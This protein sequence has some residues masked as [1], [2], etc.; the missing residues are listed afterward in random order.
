MNE[1]E[2]KQRE[3]L[4][5]LLDTPAVVQRVDVITPSRLQIAAM[6]MTAMLSNATYVATKKSLQEIAE[7]SIRLADIL[8][9]QEQQLK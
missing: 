3:K 7:N 2:L 4:N 9:E 6:A 8:I 5:E 1:Y